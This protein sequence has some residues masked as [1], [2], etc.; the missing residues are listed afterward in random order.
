M[1]YTL[2]A[3][4]KPDKHGVTQLHRLAEDS[5]INQ[6]PAEF[7]TWETMSIRD[8]RNQTPLEWVIRLGDYAKLPKQFFTK[9][10]F[11]RRDQDGYT[12]M[13]AAALLGTL[14]LLPIEWF[15]ADILLD[16]PENEITLIECHLFFLWRDRQPPPPDSFIPL[17]AAH[18]PELIWAFERAPN[19]LPW[20]GTPEWNEWRY[21]LAK[22]GFALRPTATSSSKVA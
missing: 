15:T 14:H 6:V 7:V 9:E 11:N 3:L 17:I 18:F 1:P 12:A 10:N 4:T 5:K 19:E 20:E 8:D 22:A 21:K 13:Y 16:Q 2:A